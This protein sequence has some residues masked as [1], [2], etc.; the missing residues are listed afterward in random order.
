MTAGADPHRADP[1]P[2][3]TRSALPI[4]S[5]LPSREKVAEGRMRGPRPA[6]RHAPSPAANP[7]PLLRSD[8]SRN[9][10]GDTI[11]SLLPS[12]EKVAEGRMRGPRPAARHAPSPAANP[13]PLLRSDLSRNGRGD[14]IMSLLPSREK[15]AEGRMRGH[16]L[17]PDT[18][19]RPPRTLTRCFAATSPGTGEVTPSCPFSPRGRR[20]PKAG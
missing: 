12:R 2:P 8:L 16:V 3:P 5:L 17:L 20:W 1:H 9:G 18:R 19:P 4:M 10:R 13:H 7:H 14:T 11:M 15:V 6:A